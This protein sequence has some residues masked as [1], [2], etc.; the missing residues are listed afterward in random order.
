MRWGLGPVFAFESLL[1]A[2]RWQTFA[3]R[4]ALIGALLIGL[5]V[6]W[7]THD[8]RRPRASIRSQ[9]Q[10]GENYFYALVGTE[11]ALVMLAA[12]AATA[13]A[14]CVDRSRGMLAHILVTDLTDSEIILGK[15][16]ARLLPVMGLVA[17][18]WPAVALG[19]FL[20]GIDPAA[21]TSA[22]GV[23]LAVG[24]LG[25]ALALTISVWA[26]KTHEVVL[27]TY[28]FWMLILVAYPL[29][30]AVSLLGR[31]PGPPRW[32][33]L[34]N[35]FYLAFAPYIEPAK[36]TPWHFVAYFAIATTA[37]AALV[38]LAIVRIR[39][40]ATHVTVR[41]KRQTF[42]TRPINLLGGLARRL[43]GPS[44]EGNPVFWREWHRARPSRLMAWLVGSIAVV[45]TLPTVWDAIHLIRN[46]LGAMG[47]RFGAIA[48]MLQMILGLLMLAAAAPMSLSEERQR[49]S[50]D[51]LLATPLSTRSIVR[52]KWLGAFRLIPLLVI[53]PTLI[54]LAMGICDMSG[55]LSTFPPATRVFY[56]TMPLRVRLTA[57]MVVPFTLVA[58]G[59]AT[60]SV[61]LALAT[62]IKRQSQAVAAGVGLFVMTAIVWPI[63]VSV[64]FPMPGGRDSFGA[65]AASLSPILAVT[66]MFDLLYTRFR[67]HHTI[68]VWIVLWNCV[69]TALAAAV[70]EFTMRTFDQKFERTPEWPASVGAEPVKP[71]AEVELAFDH[72]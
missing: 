13:G 66:N 59:A 30:T 53:C 50:L 25:C 47:P 14:I 17:C 16:A 42:M 61:G 45:T 29:W 55:W 57:V 48:A 62:W 44:L 33:L 24:I 64:A 22:L 54:A 43:P 37:S 68:V 12:P 3:A 20:G 65:R 9:A 49:G 8:A 51:V 52:G 32:V 6:I 23:V 72:A 60:A 41:K 21:L 15:L 5:S 10:I 7:W 18:S 28:T 38:V 67:N 40:V 58:H 27:A 31:I 35:P 46:G 2:R 1:S 4:A 56:D 71:P 26:K 11:L 36:I 63:F 70:L 34:A 19:S 39:R 69:V